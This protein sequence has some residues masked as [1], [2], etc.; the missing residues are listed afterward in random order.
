MTSSEK[1]EI[2]DVVGDMLPATIDVIIDALQRLGKNHLVLSIKDSNL[3]QIEELDGYDFE[4]ITGADSLN[5][6]QKDY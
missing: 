6:F 2:M 1:S 3:D 5:D 4:K